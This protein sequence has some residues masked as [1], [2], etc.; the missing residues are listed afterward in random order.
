MGKAWRIVLTVVIS[1]MVIGLVL[2]GAAWITGASP[3][4]IVELVFG[5]REGLEAWWETAVQTAQNAWDSLIA[6][7]ENLF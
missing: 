7:I 3:E 6:F 5:G 4:R 1:L 2:V